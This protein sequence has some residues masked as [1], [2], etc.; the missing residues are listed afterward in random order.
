[1]ANV[2]FGARGDATPATAW[3]RYA[4]IDQW[5]AWAPQITR[6]ERD[7]ERIA[8]GVVGRVVGPLGVSADFHVDE[9]DETARRWSWTVRRFVLTVRLQH[10]V[11]ADGDGSRTW[12][13]IDAPLPV[14]LAY[15]PI[16]RF[17]LRRLVADG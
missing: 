14:V 9:V 5:A 1:V 4:Q 12:L 7:S 10:G 13:T 6:V 17:A 8:P 2:T 15:A 3:E 16:A 11:L